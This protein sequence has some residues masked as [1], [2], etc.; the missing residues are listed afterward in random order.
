[1]Y[2]EMNNRMILLE[3]SA[4][5]KVLAPLKKATINTLFARTVIEKHLQGKVFVD[6]VNS[7]N[8]FYIVHPYGMSL[9]FGNPDNEEFNRQ[10]KEHALNKDKS[11]DKYEWMQVF[12]DSWDDKL[13]D[14]FGSDL[15]K[16]SDNSN[17]AKGKVELNGRVNFKFNQETYFAFKQNTPKIN[18]KI[19]PTDK[20]IFNDMKGS[21]VPMFFWKD[22]EH[23][24]KHGVGFSLFYDNKLA[25]TAYSAYIHDNYLELGIETVGEYRGKGLAQYACSVL[26]DY[27]LQNNYEPVWSCRFENTAS[28]KLAQKLGF[29]PVPKRTYYK[30]PC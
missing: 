19:V 25:S 17:T 14:L 1:M 16:Y 21:V 11:R 5:N 22:A 23:F 12:P 24:C 30:L 20:E 2:K 13:K 28:L 15:V 3:E 6:D 10:F 7:P 27:C 4:Y 8:T 29:E 18:C 26:I 9:L